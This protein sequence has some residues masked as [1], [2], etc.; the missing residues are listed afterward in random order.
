VQA[1]GAQIGR[2]GDCLEVRLK[3]GSKSTARLRE[4][5][6]LN[7]FGHVSL[8]PAATQE[9][10]HR[11]IDVSFFGFG[12]WFYGTLGGFPEKNVLLRIAQF[13]TAARPDARLAIAREMVTGKIL[14]SRTLLRRNADEGS[15]SALLDLKTLAGRAQEATSEGEL[16]GLEGNAAKAYFRGFAG[17]L[18]PRSGEGAAFDFEGR[19][20]RPPRDP[21]NALLS[22]GYALL[23]K[24]ARIALLS[25]G[26]D[27][28]VGLYHRPRSGRPAL[29]LDLMEEF[30]SLIVDSTVLSAIN[31]EVVRDEHF[32][33]AAGGC[34]LNDTGRKAF[35]GAYERRM[36]QEVTHPMFGYTV[37]YRRIL[38]T[39]ARLLSRVVLGELPRYPS[40]RT[41]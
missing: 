4:V 3:D 14:N 24:D 32:V 29:A 6:Q 11:G 34:A 30:R 18:A 15:K 2:S 23:A 31:T 35:L 12:G 1:Y 16:L 36:N 17:L 5:S 22:L 38:H 10:C 27:P 8:T 41:R 19:N 13:A 20:R 39:Q 9:L 37:S 28:S 7:V 26:F 40:F 25:V 33:R 21:V